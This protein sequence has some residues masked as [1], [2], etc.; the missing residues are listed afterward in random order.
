M[1]NEGGTQTIDSLGLIYNSALK[2][3]DADLFVS[4]TAST[5]T[6]NTGTMDI[7]N[8]GVVT[9]YGSVLNHRFGADYDTHLSAGGVL[10][11]GSQNEPGQ[12]NTAQSFNAVIESGGT[13]N[14]QNGGISQGSTVQQGGTLVVQAN[15]HPE[16][17]NIAP[18]AGVANNSIVYGE[19]DNHGSTDNDTV[20]KVGGRYSSG[21]ARSSDTN[22]ENI[23]TSNNLLVEQGG[24]AQLSGYSAI[25]NMT[26]AGMVDSRDQSSLD[27]T[28]ITST[29]AMTD[30][31][32]G[33][34][35]R[36]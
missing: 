23:S 34:Q 19:I 17:Q 20:V 14:I 9:G 13:Q 11:T 6:I 31:H 24:Y 25:N 18:T 3:Q 7:L 32:R 30:D 36:Q 4:G 35:L 28:V 1:N 22:T 16:D 27:D 10:N 12:I 8:G 21:Y 29:G 26:V 15:Y 2:S 33:R 5:I